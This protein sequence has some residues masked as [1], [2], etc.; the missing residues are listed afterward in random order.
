MP[1][2]KNF[3]DLDWTKRHDRLVIRCT[4]TFTVMVTHDV[5]SSQS[6]QTRM[7]WLVVKTKIK[8]LQT[9]VWRSFSSY[10][11]GRYKPSRSVSTKKINKDLHQSWLKMK[12]RQGE[13]RGGRSHDWPVMSDTSFFN[14]NSPQSPG[15]WDLPLSRRATRS[16]VY[17]S[18]QSEDESSFTPHIGG[19]CCSLSCRSAGCTG[20]GQSGRGSSCA[21]AAAAALGCGGKALTRWPGSSPA[22]GCQRTSGP[23]WSPAAASSPC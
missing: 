18:Y 22:P 3:K 2:P 19:C 13:R 23:V 14:T 7:L 10:L 5:L 16:N 20:S 11:P 12:F 21:A 15:D 8:H 9:V 17:D 4:S 6:K 1:K